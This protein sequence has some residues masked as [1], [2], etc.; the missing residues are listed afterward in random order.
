MKKYQTFGARTKE[1]SERE[2]KHKALARR[3]AAEGIVLFKRV[4]PVKTS[5]W[6]QNDE[7]LH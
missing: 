2:R 1:E 7:H 6:R 3:A 4:S 5:E